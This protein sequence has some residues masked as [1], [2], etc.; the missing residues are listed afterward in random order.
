MAKT[1]LTEDQ[2]EKL[3][4]SIMWRHVKSGNLC[5]MLF[6]SHCATSGAGDGLPCVVY[7]CYD[8]GGNCSLWHCDVTQFLDGR[9]VPETE[10]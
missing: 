4:Q 8:K 9:F 10:Y 1:E 6:I 2:R 5:E 3:N 7:R